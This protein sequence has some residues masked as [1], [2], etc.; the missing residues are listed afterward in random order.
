MNCISF[1]IQTNSVLRKSSDLF[2]SETA[3]N[4]NTDAFKKITTI[5]ISCITFVLSNK[6]LF[7]TKIITTDLS[8]P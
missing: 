7:F 4:K 1:L 2:F 5:E 6:M 3:S 8:L